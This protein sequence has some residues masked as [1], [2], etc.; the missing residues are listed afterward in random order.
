MTR[1]GDFFAD[2]DAH[3][4]AP[5]GSKTPLRIIGSTA[6]M[7]QSGYDRGTKD[8]DVLETAAITASVKAHL[9]AV[10]GKGSD[11]H[12]RH[13]LYVEVVGHAIPFL[14]QRAL[15]HPQAELNARLRNFDLE[16]LDVVDVAVSKLKRFHGDDRPALHPPGEPCTSSQASSSRMLPVARP[17]HVSAAP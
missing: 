9:L 8:S 13:R 6:L 4:G 15:Y 10:G 17:T 12:R 11:L 16:V 2:L 3:W 7:L 5:A 1:I 14:P